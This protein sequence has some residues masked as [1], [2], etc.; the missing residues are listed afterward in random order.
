[1]SAF[2]YKPPP[3]IGFIRSSVGRFLGKMPTNYHLLAGCMMGRPA[4]GGFESV[5]GLE[6][7]RANWKSGPLLS[8]GLASNMEK[9]PKIGRTCCRKAS[10]VRAAKNRVELFLNADFNQTQESGFP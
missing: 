10:I 7:R 8:S 1:M 3:Y 6:W 2:C 4:G 5:H 9:E